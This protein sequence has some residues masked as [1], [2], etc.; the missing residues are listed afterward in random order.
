VIESRRSPAT[1]SPSAELDWTEKVVLVATRSL[2]PSYGGISNYRFHTAC[3]ETG[4]TQ[5][6]WDAALTLLIS[7]KLLKPSNAI[8]D[9]GRSAVL[10]FSSLS[11]LKEQSA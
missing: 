11:A 2:K 9:A 4:I 10:Q 3:R 7:R 1:N 5:G 6:E 8:T